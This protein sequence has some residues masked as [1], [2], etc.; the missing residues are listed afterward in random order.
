MFESL[1]SLKL[2]QQTLQ[3]STIVAEVLQ[4]VAAKAVHVCML[5]HILVDPIAINSHDRYC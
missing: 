3:L 5:A 4:T 1:W 2:I